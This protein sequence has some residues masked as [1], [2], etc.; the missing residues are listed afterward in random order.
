M[1]MKFT[2]IPADTFE[3]LQTNAGILLKTFDPT[4]VTEVKEEDIIS[5]TKGGVTATCIMTPKDLGEEI[6]NAPKN[7]MELMVIESWECKM[8]ATLVGASPDTIKLMLGA[9]DIDTATGK[10]TPRK[11]LKVSD[12]VDLWW[13]GDRADGG[14]YA[15]HLKNALNTGGFSLK[16]NDKGNG[17][18]TLDATGHFSLAKQDEVPME[19]FVSEPKTAP[20]V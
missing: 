2:R 18:F 12:F 4:G 17:E 7:A 6:D 20:A 10:I 14:A 1:A 11:D 8:G 13:V 16:T 15:I 9:A 5:A 19:F 3:N